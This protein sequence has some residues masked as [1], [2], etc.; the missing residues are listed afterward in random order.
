MIRRSEGVPPA[1]GLLLVRESGDGRGFY[2]RDPFG[3][4]IDVIER[5]A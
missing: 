4:I 2:F 1:G 3:L 5:G